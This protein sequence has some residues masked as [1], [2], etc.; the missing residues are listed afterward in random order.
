[1]RDRSLVTIAALAANGDVEQLGSYIK[2]GLQSGLTRAEI[3][4]A[5]TH[6]AFYAGWPRATSAISVA[7]NV[8]R[9]EGG[10]IGPKEQKLNV[11]PPDQ[12]AR[13]APATNFIGRATVT[14]PFKA[15]GGAR[16]GGATVSF[17][18]GARTNWHIHPLGQLLVITG[19]QGWL[20]AEGESVRLVKVGDVVWTAPGVKHWHGATES[21]GLSHTA[22][23]ET[24][25][26]LS[27]T[28]HEPVTDRQYRGPVK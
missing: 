27:V 20:Q 3:G 14:S 18:P 9:L 4:E 13:I 11:V 17:E 16:L 19:G 15:T 26:G 21:G 6:L 25:E 22:V 8:F 5:L 10:S 2:R 28:W 12:D 24:T 7:E 23:A 1:V